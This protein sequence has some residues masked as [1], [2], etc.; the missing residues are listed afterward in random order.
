QSSR[1]P[2]VEVGTEGVRIH[3]PYNPELRE[4]LR[5]LP[6]VKWVPGHWAVPHSK[7]AVAVE[8]LTE[9]LGEPVVVDRRARGTS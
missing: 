3:A 2:T 7:R 1:R 6:G 8:L 9:V 5:T 4:A